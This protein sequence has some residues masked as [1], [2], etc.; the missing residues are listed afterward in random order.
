M[1]GSTNGQLTF[2]IISN[3]TAVS[4]DFEN[5]ADKSGENVQG[6]DNV[7]EVNVVALAGNSGG[8]RM[9]SVTVTDVNEDPV[10]MDDTATTEEDTAVVIS[11]LGNDTDV[12]ATTTLSV[13]VDT[14]PTH[15]AAVITAGS[16]TTITYTP[17]ADF[18]GT[19][20]FDYTV[21]DGETQS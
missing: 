7:Y 20:S 14:D 4:P 5:P 2:S 16:T 17:N 12:D 13:T 9:V 21:S 10:A 15:G 11:V 6:G 1:V 3:D 8:L 18:N 19:D